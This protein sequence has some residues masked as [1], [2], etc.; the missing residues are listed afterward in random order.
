MAIPQGDREHPAEVVNEVDPVV[1]VEMHKGLYIAFGTKTVSGGKKLLAEL[2]EVVDLS[3]ADCPDRLVLIAHW[4]LASSRIDDGETTHSE[5]D[6]ILP[7]RAVA[8]RP[9]MHKKPEHPVYRRAPVRV[10]PYAMPASYSTHVERRASSAKSQWAVG[11]VHA[12]GRVSAAIPLTAAFV[13]AQHPAVRRGPWAVAGYAT[14]P[15]W[16]GPLLAM[17]MLTPGCRLRCRFSARV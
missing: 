5:L 16:V 8:V 13:P 10:V 9:P 6:A 11:P 17:A 3:V 1:L 2:S 4:L 12:A 7:V 15:A 14:L